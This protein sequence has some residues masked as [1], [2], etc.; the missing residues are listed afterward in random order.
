M[1]PSGAM[2]APIC[3]VVPT[4][5]TRAGGRFLAGDAVYDHPTPVDGDST[6]PALL[7]SLEQLDN[8]TFFLLVLVAVATPEVAEPAE[9]RVGDMV[10]SSSVQGLVFGSAALDSLHAHLEN[11]GLV[12]ATRFLCLAGYPNVRNLQLAI[13][14]CLESQA[15]VALDDDE[16]VTDPLFLSKAT[17]PLGREIDGTRLDGLSGYYLQPDGGIFLKVDA[18][19]ERSPNIFERKASI[20]NYAVRQLEAES[21]NIVKT[22][23][24]FG[25]NMEFSRE[26]AEG[27][28]F[29]P[30]ITRGEDIDY[31]INARMEGK[32]IFLRRDLR[33]LHCPPRGGSYRDTTLTKLEQDIVRF[34]YERE[35]VKASQSIEDLYPVTVDDL[36]PYPGEFLEDDLGGAAAAALV[37]H[38][39]QGDPTEYV[40][41]IEDGA[42]RRMSQYLDFRQRWPAVVQ[43]I[44]DDRDLREQLVAAT[45]TE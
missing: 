44:E 33:I 21:G 34:V 27:V 23:F 42:R 38:G 9:R 18:D 24:C 17:D 10:R 14:L 40:R 8:S 7:E 11:R 1:V 26:L 31:L 41:S 22:S 43:V 25:G 6:L 13:P 30:G 4:Y 29:D 12:E 36:I 28:G 16:I 20:M 5:W 2:L 3:V 37:A 32:T 19:Q 35:K 45:A 39:F 15:I